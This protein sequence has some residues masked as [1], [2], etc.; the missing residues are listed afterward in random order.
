MDPEKTGI[1]TMLTQ[2][3]ITSAKPKVAP[4]NL[5][6]GQG[7]VL[8]IQTTGSKLWRFRYRYAGRQKTLHI[9]PWPATSLADAR[10]KCR[11]ARKA[12]AAGLDPALERKREKVAARFAVATTFKEVALEWIAK[13]ER[14]GRAEIT[15]DKIRWLLG[16]AYQDALRHDVPADA[17]WM[18]WRKHDCHRLPCKAAPARIKRADCKHVAPARDLGIGRDPCL[19]GID[20]LLDHRGELLVANSKLAKPGGLEYARLVAIPPDTP[21]NFLARIEKVGRRIELG[22]GRPWILDE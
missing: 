6:D 22:G 16:M 10:E 2:L 7:L 17:K 11:K 3:Q 21:G 4:Y 12:I 1:T 9:G 5:S 14:E 8:A 15:L 20:V 13:C 19:V 18:E